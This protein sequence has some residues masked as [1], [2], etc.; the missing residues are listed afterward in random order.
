MSLSLLVAG[1]A[2][3]IAPATAAAAKPSRGLRFQ[4]SPDAASLGD[5][6]EIES[7]SSGPPPPPSYHT[8]NPT[9]V[10]SVSGQS[11]VSC[12]S[13]ATSTSTA[14]MTDAH[15]SVIAAIFAGFCHSTDPGLT[16]ATVVVEAFDEAVAFAEASAASQAFCMSTGNAFGCASATASAEAWASASAA[17]HATAVAAAADDCD[18]VSSVS[19]QAVAAAST[20]LALSAEAFA[21]AEALACSSGDSESYAAAYMSCTAASTAVVWTK[22]V[23]EVFAEGTCFSTEVAID[24]LAETSGDFAILTGCNRDTFSI[25]DAFAKSQGSDI[26]TVR[27]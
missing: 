24:I 18:C 19:M 11:S 20:F 22:A 3:A 8:A 17:A 10:R 2:L 14:A 16:A 5:K 6:F 21:S 25:G 23:A 9:S 27:Y 12:I 13:Q 1:A 4:L 26:G 7:D 15:A